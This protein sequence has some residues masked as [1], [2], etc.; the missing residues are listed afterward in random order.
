MRADESDILLALHR[1]AQATPPWAAFFTSLSARTGAARVQLVLQTENEAAIEV[2]GG[3]FLPF[4][5]EQL[6]RMRPM[7]PYSG[8]DYA[9]RM[10]Y[11]ALRTRVEDGGNAWIIITREGED[12]AAA[13]SALLGTL[14]PH[15]GLAVAQFWNSRSARA[16]EGAMHDMAARLGLS[17]ALL[18]RHG[19]T[20]ATSAGLPSAYLNGGRL[21]LSTTAMQ[22]IG[23]G[24]EDYWAGV[25]RN[26]VVIALDT[27]QALLLPFLGHGAVAIL[28]F[29]TAKPSPQGAVRVLAD[30]LDLTPAEARFAVELV[31]GRSISQAGD[32]LNLTQETARYYSKQLY[33]KLGA[34]GQ[35]DVIRKV[36]HSVYRLL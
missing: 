11:R 32:A 1:S 6:A 13:T 17:W 31:G 2:F 22:Q 9:A 30:L 26:P 28:Y 19:T 4:E 23:D 21:R 7:R 27:V 16:Y 34:T 25:H 14:A 15:L 36:A 8:A 33:A 35:A 5:A 12:F 18:S 3:P 10:P 29:Q 20:I 24:L